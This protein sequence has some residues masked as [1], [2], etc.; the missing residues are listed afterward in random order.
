[1]YVVEPETLFSYDGVYHF[2]IPEVGEA[3]PQSKEPEKW[4]ARL[5]KVAKFSCS[6]YYGTVSDQEGRLTMKW[7]QPVKIENVDQFFRDHA[8]FFIGKNNNPMPYDEKARGFTAMVENEVTGQNQEVVMRPDHERL[9]KMKLVRPDWYGSLP[10]LICGSNPV[11]NLKWRWKNVRSVD[12]QRL[13]GTNAGSH[14]EVR[15][16]IPPCFWMRGITASCLPGR[17]N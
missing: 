6:A 2:V 8:E 17:A 15:R 7:T 16:K 5:G 1:M 3:F 14:V 13:E 10:V 11:F 9:A 4:D 12:G